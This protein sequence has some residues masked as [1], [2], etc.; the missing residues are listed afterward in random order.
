MPNW[1]FRHRRSLGSAVKNCMTILYLQFFFLSHQNWKSFPTVGSIRIFWNNHAVEP[2]FLRSSSTHFL[3]VAILT[4]H[5]EGINL[6]IIVVF[7]KE[8][9]SATVFWFEDSSVWRYFSLSAHENTWILRTSFNLVMENKQSLSE[10]RSTVRT[11]FHFTYINF[12]S[13]NVLLLIKSAPIRW[14]LF[15]RKLVNNRW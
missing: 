3:T 15:N 8:T 5:K 2:P 1:K 13:I 6:V 4:F 10:F 11:T 9:A 7:Y 12:I 14:I